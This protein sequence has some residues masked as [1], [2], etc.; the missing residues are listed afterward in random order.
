MSEVTTSTGAVLVGQTATLRLRARDAQGNNHTTGGLTVV[1]SVAGGSSQ[2]T[3][4]PTRDN[5]DG[6]YEADFTG[7]VGG[8]A[9][10]VSATVNGSPVTSNLPT[11]LVAVA[12]SEVCEAQ[13]GASC[14]YVAANGSDSNPGTFDAPFRLPQTAVDRAGPGDFIY[15]RGGAEFTCD[16]SISTDSRHG[17]FLTDGGQDG[18]SGALITIKSLPGEQAVIRGTAAQNANFVVNRSWWRVEGLRIDYGGLYVA[19]Y[20][21]AGVHDV[22]VVGNEVSRKVFPADNMGLI[23]IHGDPEGTEDPYNIYVWN[24][25]VYDLSQPGG[26]W[27]DD[28][29][30]LHGCLTVQ[31]A[32]GYV[33]FVGNVAYHCPSFLFFKYADQPGPALVEGNRFYGG[34]QGAPFSID[35]MVFR[36]NFVAI[37]G[38][39]PGF[40]VTGVRRTFQNNT[41]S[42][43]GSRSAVQWAADIGSHTFRDNVIMGREYMG[44]GSNASGDFSAS[45]IDGNC[46][47]WDNSLVALSANPDRDWDQYRAEFGHDANA[48]R[49]L[50]TSF[51][52]VFAD[53]ANRDYTLIGAAASQCPGAG[54]S[55]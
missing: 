21:Q 24:N 12:G 5:G 47:I 20:F 46:I 43:P 40:N 31:R 34:R 35:D 11:I 53:T 52:A 26:T 33:E 42:L 49:V 1:F 6:T 15:L 51:N 48:V 7:T 41:F 17:C 45:D 27:E 38:D 37:Q 39:G 10:T 44:F 4:G 22:W 18:Q 2:G 13:G 14:W 3:I 28:S 19:W 25:V 30:V 55:P 29:G 36:N 32:S 8:T 54:A 23:Y 50:E 9:L 16:H